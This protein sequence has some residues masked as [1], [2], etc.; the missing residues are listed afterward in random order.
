RSVSCI[1]E[2]L[3]E[4]WSWPRSLVLS[5]LRED[6]DIAAF[7]LASLARK[8][9]LLTAQVHALTFWNAAERVVRTFVHLAQMYGE[10]DATGSTRITLRITQADVGDIACA[11]R[12]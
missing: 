4:T 10:P 1:A 5:L 9:D 2:E 7:L 12:V 3:T 8:I 6:G 11:S